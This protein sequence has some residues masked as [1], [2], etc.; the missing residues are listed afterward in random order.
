MIPKISRGSDPAGLVKYL[1]GKGRHNE[2]ANQHL[3]AC[4]D[5]LL[6]SF[7]FDGHPDESYAKIGER[8][9]RRYRVRERKGDPFPRDR[10]GRHNPGGEHGKDRVWHCSLSI[11]ASQG[12]LTDG[13]WEAIVRDYLERMSILPDDGAA[14][15]TW[16]AV[17]HGLSRNG[18]DHVHVMVQLATDDGWIN[19][20]N[21]MKAAQ[22]SCRGMER[23]RS[24]LVEIG[25]SNTE[26]QVRYRYAEWRRWAEWKAQEDYDGPLPW[27]ALD[28]TSASG[29]SRPWPRRRCRNSTSAGS[30]RRARRRHGARTSSSDA[31]AARASA[32]TRV[33]A[34]A[35]P[36][37]RSIRRIKW[38]DT[39]SHGAAG[40]A[41]RNGST[42]PTSAR[43]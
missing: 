25:R 27:H 26:S 8:F 22:R 40:T 24:E 11:K 7:G 30:W 16:L 20:Y 9:D 43:T 32:S 42:R 12:I 17:R 14:G 5:D 28:R 6:D 23:E 37:I 39:G 36:G 33:C 41:G 4:S 21:D 29:E 10:R 3:V 35:R 13:Q 2:H 38:S 18:N 31:S 19:T 15:V 34:R 1:F